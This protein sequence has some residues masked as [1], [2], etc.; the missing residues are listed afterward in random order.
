MRDD[1]V[2]SDAGFDPE[3]LARY[4]RGESDSSP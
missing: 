2:D 4:Q 1:W 3:E